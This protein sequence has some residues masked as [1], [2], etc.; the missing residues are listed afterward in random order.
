M[1][2]SLYE[3]V[4]RQIVAYLAEGTK[5][6]ECPWDCTTS[7][8]LIP[9]NA[10]TGM[11]Y[12]GVNVLLTWIA[13]QEQGFGSPLYLTF[14]QALALGGRVL[15]GSK[16]TRLIFFK[17]LT[18]TAKADNGE[19]RTI[20]I[21][22]IRK[23]VVF[24]LDQVAGIQEEKFE[25]N[26]SIQQATLQPIEQ[27][28]AI[29]KA[30]PVTIIEAGT[31]AF[32]SPNFDTIHLPDPERYKRVEDRYATALHEMAHSSGHP[33]R[34][35]RDLC[36]TYGSK[37]YAFEELVAEMASAYLMSHLQFKGE[38]MGHASYLDDWLQVLQS[39]SKAIFK[40]ASLAQKATEYLLKL[41][42]DKKAQH[43]A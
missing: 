8:G 6:W 30:C 42:D 27:A 28:E 4:T 15:K 10:A 39:D 38:L 25:E 40:A 35:N 9:K 33:R 22:M 19:E 1:N 43:A 7:A 5:P 37:A 34:L 13:A 14:K 16:G 2:N 12:T 11:P 41:V 24:N 26:G 32:Y 18:R 29:L 36:G 31:K 3:E 21:P 20:T 23:F 17:P